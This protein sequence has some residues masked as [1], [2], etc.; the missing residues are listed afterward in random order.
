MG[1]KR[2]IKKYKMEFILTEEDF[3]FEEF[4]SQDFQNVPVNSTQLQETSDGTSTEYGFNFIP[5]IKVLTVEADLRTKKRPGRLPGIPDKDLSPIELDRRQRKRER[6]RKAA[7]RVRSRRLAKEHTL[8]KEIENLK[9]STDE[10]RSSN[11][12]LKDQLKRLQS[13]IEH[14]KKDEQCALIMFLKTKSI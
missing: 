13:K 4:E 1:I 14:Q 2:N 7:A 12:S 3:S 5:E 8:I 9:Q 6:N 10:L 11:L